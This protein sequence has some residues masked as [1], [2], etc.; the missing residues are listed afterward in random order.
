MRRAK[1]KGSVM[2]PRRPQAV[3]GCK[4]FGVCPG[5]H[6]G[7]SRSGSGRDADAA[8][9]GAD[10]LTIPPDPDSNA[11]EDLGSDQSK[12]PSAD[13]NPRRVGSRSS[14]CHLPFGRVSGHG[15][16]MRF[17]VG[18]GRYVSGWD[19]LSGSNKAEYMSICN[20]WCFGIGRAVR[21]SVSVFIAE[22]CLHLQV[23]SSTTPHPTL[24]RQSKAISRDKQLYL[25]RQ[26]TNLDPPNTIHHQTIHHQTSHNHG[27]QWERAWGA[28]CSRRD[29]ASNGTG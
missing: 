22:M 29:G 9:A 15:L 13:S 27:E 1:R 18:L 26:L 28:A 2:F 14:G 7:I 3:D 5:V 23:A 17:G 10:C 12:S 8:V 21:V 4:C 24:T 20:R 11:G 25:R 16:A 6:F 19:L